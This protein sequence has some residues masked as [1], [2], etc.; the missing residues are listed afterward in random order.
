MKKEQ[1]VSSAADSQLEDTDLEKVTGGSERWWE[2]KEFT[3]K[4]VENPEENNE[5]N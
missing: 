1:E 5:T 3:P 4:P 2:C